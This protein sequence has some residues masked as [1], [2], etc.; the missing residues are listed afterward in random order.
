MLEFMRRRARSTWIKVI[1]LIIIAVFI[2]WGVGG[3]V[4]GNRPDIV[5]RVDGQVISTREF[6]RAYENV[7]SAY[8]ETY[9]DRL[10]PDLLEKLNLREQT[11]DQLVNARLLAAEAQR[12]GFTAS[13]EEVR[14]AISALEV[15]QEHGSFSQER[16]LTV[17]RYLRLTPG[18]FE[19]DQRSQL[20]LK[21]LQ[22]LITDAPRVTDD[23]VRELFRLGREKVSLSFVKIASADLL[24]GVTVEP[25]EVEDYY[26]T[27]RESFRQPERVKFAYVAYPATQF[28]SGG[29]VS[30]QDVEN[31]YT[32][33]TEDRF[34]T[35]A[36]VHARHILFSLPSSAAAEEK[37][38]VRATATAVLTR[39]RAGEDFATLA[40]T[41]SQDTA[42]APNG[43]DLEFFTR[44]RM[45]K[46]FED[47]A[48]AL[49]VGGISELVE[50]SFGLH[51][52]KVE[53]NE[54]ERVRPLTE[55]EAEIRQELT[56]TRARE[57]AQ[58]R[59][60]EDRVKIQ[61]G[62]AVAEVAQAAG[63][64]VVE[65]PLVARD[66]N[67]PDLGRQPA[68]I[69]AALALAP[70]QVSE[71][72][73]VEDTW[74]LVSPREKVPSTI[75][76]FAAVKEEAEKQLRSDKAEQLAK[77][78]AEALLA[79]VKETKDL[80]AAAAEQKLTVEESGPFT[81]QGGYIPKMGS[82]PE[83]KRAAFRLTPEAPVA[84]QTAFWGGNAFVAVLKEQIPPDAQEFEKQKESI[85]EQQLKRKQDEAL[86]ELVRYLKK[87]A[88]I[89]YNQDA[90]LKTPS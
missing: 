10:T 46:P 49:P 84:P 66:E 50:T 73:A 9:K 53:A 85:R 78:K 17:L 88:T 29:E 12:L 67:I 89:T 62:A 86:N 52:I 45:V 82:L 41:Y 70:Q 83:L 34:T 30:V 4:S 69:A 63:L 28:E 64:T 58:E 61:N 16:Y 22:R 24:N 25:K 37:A 68:L 35:P 51:I 21:K 13:D 36:R 76:D 18:E 8:R 31:F 48:F 54:P 87:R 72:V 80:A 5:A 55:V 65:T 74:Y 27:H 42:T 56:R 1:F 90:L 15:F 11:L 23:E 79:R 33:H 71:P 39:A 20:L 40:K 44:G 57:R 7:K 3:S 14:Q 6:Q 59:A 26:N 19:D 2:F 77:E 60:R 75:L 47:A 81:R 38:T 43:G 32:E